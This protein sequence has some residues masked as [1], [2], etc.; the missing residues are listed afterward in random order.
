MANR[1]DPTRFSRVEL[2]AWS[3]FL[4]T[5]AA[6]VRELDARLQ[7]GHGMTFRAYDVLATLDMTRA[8]RLR[9]TDLADRLV[10]SPSRMTRVVARLEE[11][12]WIAREPSPDDARSQIAT[13]TPSG[14]RALRAARR[15]HHAVVRERVLDRLE[16]DDLRALARI[17]RTLGTVD[18]TLDEALETLPG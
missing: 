6:L 5:H 3:G 9:M 8:R 11:L 13:L 10:L 14:V 12:G 18:P 4:S 15:T 2:E 16:E 1:R 7:A 17:W